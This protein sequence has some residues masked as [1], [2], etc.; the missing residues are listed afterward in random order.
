[1]TTYTP[2]HYPNKKQDKNTETNINR[3][4]SHRHSKIY[5]LTRSCPLEEKKIKTSLP[6][7]RTQAQ[8]TL[9]KK[10]THTTQPTFPLKDKN[11]EKKE[12]KPKAW[13]K[14]TSN[15]KQSK[16]GGKNEKTENSTMKQQTHKTK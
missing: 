11:Q 4:E 1:M 16:L 12:Y 10:S 13:K 7:T 6:S 3:Q 15:L 9:N 5:H 8:V 2:G 14:E